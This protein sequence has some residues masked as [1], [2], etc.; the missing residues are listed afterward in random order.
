MCASAQSERP[1]SAAA[2][3]TTA[4]TSSRSS[5]SSARAVRA[6]VTDD[7]RCDISSTP[8][9]TGGATAVARMNRYDGAA[10]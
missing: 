1:R 10:R 5:R 7:K 6:A 3:S 2:S 8:A 4:T 9:A